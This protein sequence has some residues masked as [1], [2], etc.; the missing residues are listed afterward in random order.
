MNLH[1]YI[2][3]SGNTGNDADEWSIEGNYPKHGEFVV[4]LFEEWTW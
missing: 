4:K 3:E 2:W 1:D